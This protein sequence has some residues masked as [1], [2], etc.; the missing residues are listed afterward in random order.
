MQNTQDDMIKELFVAETVG[1]FGAKN[2]SP[3]V[4]FLDSVDPA[5]KNADNPNKDKDH[6]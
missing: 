4:K 6:M 5:P 2:A 3:L 1:S